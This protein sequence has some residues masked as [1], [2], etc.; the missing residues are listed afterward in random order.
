MVEDI[1]TALSRMRWLFVIARNSSFTYKGRAVDVKQ[2]GRELGVRYGLEGSVRKAANR[3]RITGQLIDADHRNASVGRPLR[4][5][6]RGYFRA[7]GSASQRASSAR[8]RRS[9]SRP[10]S[11][12]R[13]ASRPKVSTP[14]T[15]Y[16][17]GMASLH[18]WTKEGDR[19]RRCGCSTKR[20]SSTLISPRPMA[21]RPGVTFWRKVNGWMT[22]RAQEIAEA[23]AAGAAGGRAGQGRCGRA[24]PAAGSRLAMSSVTSTG[25]RDSDRSGARA[26]SEPRVGLVLRAAGSEAISASPTWRLSTSRAPCG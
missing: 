15:Y 3:L 19:A 10:R 14:T 5:R 2:V 23:D 16:L 21:W 9:W 4:R 7:A 22:D 13:S 18:R 17:R 8:L 6:A 11:S 24:L 12:A 25:G 26:Q 1:I 20:S